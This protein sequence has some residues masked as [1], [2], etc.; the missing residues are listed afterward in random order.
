MSSL[1][2]C[3]MWR[4]SKLFW[5]CDHSFWSIRL[6]CPK[7]FYRLGKWNLRK[8]GI[9]QSRLLIVILKEV[10]SSRD[11]LTSDSEEHV[12]ISI[13]P[14]ASLPPCPLTSLSADA[15]GAAAWPWAGDHR[16][17]SCRCKAC[18]T[19]NRSRAP[20]NLRGP[21]ALPKPRITQK[22][23]LFFRKVCVNFCLLQCD[24]PQEP[25]GND[26]KKLVE[27]NFFIFGV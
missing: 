19:K 17:G 25:N 1:S 14:P 3:S 6:H 22:T 7:Y 11:D 23:L 18:A 5:P 16:Q 20:A 8:N 26:S 4:S 10:G 12:H 2:D 9:K 24:T 21:K 13:Q 27:M 15:A